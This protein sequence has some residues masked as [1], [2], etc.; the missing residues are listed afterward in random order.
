MQGWV[1][2][3]LRLLGDSNISVEQLSRELSVPQFCRRRIVNLFSNNF[4]QNE[5]LVDIVGS[6]LGDI[7]ASTFFD[8]LIKQRLMFITF[9]DWGAAFN[10]SPSEKDTAVIL[11]DDMDDLPF[12]VGRGIVTHE[13]LGHVKCGHHREKV[14]R[15][16]FEEEADASATAEGFGDDILS[17]RKFKKREDK[18]GE[19]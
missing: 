18:N 6:T 9:H 3:F 16:E 8:L 12:S 4:G 17:L 7:N 14:R 19:I 5:T 10:V 15:R 1:P 2:E 13:L 11:L